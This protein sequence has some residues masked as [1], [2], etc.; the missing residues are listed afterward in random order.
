MCRNLVLTALLLILSNKTYTQSAPSAP[1]VPNQGSW[2][3]NSSQM[4][5]WACAADGLSWNAVNS[6]GSG[7]GIP[8][9]LITLIETGVC[10]TGWAEVSA[11]NGKTLIGTLA[12]NKDVGTTGG[13]DNITPE[14]TN[15]ALTFTGSSANTN[16]VSA[17]TPAGTNGTSTVTPLGT[18]NT[19]TISWPAGVPTISGTTSNSFSSVINHTHTLAT[20]TGSTGNFS[21]VI[22]TVDTSSGGTGGTPT[23]TTLGTLTVATTGGVASIT[24]TINNAGTIAWPAGVPTS[25]SLSLTGQSSTVGAQ[26]FTGSALGTHSHTLTATG[27]I[28]TPTFSGTQFDNRSAFIKVIFCK[29]D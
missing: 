14:G 8:A 3:F 29:K 21:Q 1:C 26:T 28:N 18:I 23:Q 13:L 17:G 6:V 22:G 20:G 5:A 12:A 19:P 25:N 24:P 15:G 2:T 11:L 9:G 4:Q 7:G 27:T 10:P 16:S